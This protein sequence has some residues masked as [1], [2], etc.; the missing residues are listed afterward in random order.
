MLAGRETF[1]SLVCVAC[2]RC[3]LARW[4][5]E[6]RLSHWW[7]WKDAVKG[8]PEPRKISRPGG[9][10]G[11]HS[12]DLKVRSEPGKIGRRGGT[13]WVNMPGTLWA[14]VDSYG[15]GR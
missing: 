12:D 13:L 7:C 4:P 15:N 9:T 2:W 3:S 14:A 6:S 1:E 8:G 5:D 10:L 11:E